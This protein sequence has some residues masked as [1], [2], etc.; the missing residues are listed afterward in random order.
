MAIQILSN[1]S[2]LGRTENKMS[3]HLFACDESDKGL[4][5]GDNKQAD[6]AESL[7]LDEVAELH[8]FHQRDPFLNRITSGARARAFLR[9]TLRLC[10][11]NAL[12]H[13]YENSENIQYG[14]TV[15]AT[16]PTSVKDARL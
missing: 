13:A 12:V 10:F 9:F 5:E 11:T 14:D 2:L 3:R 16:V 8:L 7:V 1:E 4:A 15:P 6:S